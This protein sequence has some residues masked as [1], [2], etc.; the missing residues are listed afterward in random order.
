M[1]NHHHAGFSQPHADFS[2]HHAGFSHQHRQ[3]LVTIMLCNKRVRNVIRLCNP[4]AN[5]SLGKY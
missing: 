2:H 4:T 3:A 5:F 1:C